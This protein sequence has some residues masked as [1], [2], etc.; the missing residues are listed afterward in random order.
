MERTRKPGKQ[1]N[2]IS[3]GPV[4]TRSTKPSTLRIELDWCGRSWSPGFLISLISPSPCL[5]VSVVPV[6]RRDFCGTTRHEC[7]G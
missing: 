7:L 5:R 3:V 1:E 6:W 2:S 4:P